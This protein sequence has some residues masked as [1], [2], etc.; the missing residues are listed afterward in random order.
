MTSEG[1]KSR[2]KMFLSVLPGELVELVLSE[3]GKV[4]E[5]LSE[6]RRLNGNNR[7]TLVA[8]YNSTDL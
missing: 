2:R 8:G 7:V 4:Q 1:K 3:E 6:L 5:F